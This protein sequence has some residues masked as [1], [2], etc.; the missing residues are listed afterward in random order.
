ME[1]PAADE[2]Q[3]FT[4]NRRFRGRVFEVVKEWDRTLFEDEPP[5]VEIEGSTGLECYCSKRCL[6]ARLALVMAAEGAPICPPGIGPIEMCAKCNGPVDMTRFHLTYLESCSG[7]YGG[8]SGNPGTWFASDAGRQSCA[9]CD[10][11]WLTKV[12][13]PLAIPRSSD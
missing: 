8:Y 11:W 7:M 10:C 6:D 5:S 12:R 4:C 9:P 1:S 13:H 3:C 2:Y